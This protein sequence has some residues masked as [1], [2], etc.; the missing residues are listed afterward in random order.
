MRSSEPLPLLT[1]ALMR[2][3]EALEAAALEAR[4]RG[5]GAVLED[6]TSVRIGRI[7]NIFAQRIA[8]AAKRGAGFNQAWGLEHPAEPELDA[9]EAFFEG[10]PFVVHVLPLTS[11]A[12]LVGSLMSRGYVLESPDAMR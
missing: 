9:L 1:P 5:L 10:E 3:L 11:S 6:P 12:A 8:A 4:L 7:G 2:Q